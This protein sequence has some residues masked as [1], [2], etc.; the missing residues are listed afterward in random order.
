MQTFLAPILAFISF[1]SSLFGQGGP[2]AAVLPGPL[3]ST[4]GNVP[5][6][7]G[8]ARLA[9]LPDK[10][11]ITKSQTF[12]IEIRLNTADKTISA[13]SLRLTYTYQGTTAPLWSSV[14]KL[15]VSPDLAKSGWVY[16]VNTIATDSRKNVNFDLALIN[17]STT[18][19]ALPPETILATVEAVGRGNG[20]R[21]TLAFDK[22]QTKVINKADK[23]L[24]LDLT[25]GVYG[26]E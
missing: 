24:V 4:G 19:S 25:G 16:A 6:A 20:E 22:S 14:M 10:G 12:P 8:Q 3:L 1:I 13:I 18:G 15:Q 23:E 7:A 5:V 26:V 11:T 21:I 9:L 2:S 17:L